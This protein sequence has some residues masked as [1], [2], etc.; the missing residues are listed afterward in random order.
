MA[1]A[2]LQSVRDALVTAYFENY[3]SDDEFVF[4]YDANRSKPVYPYWKFDNFDL[5]NWDEDECFAELRFFKSE[6]PAL[7]DC[8]GIPEKIVCSQR[9]ICG[10]MEGLCILLKRLSYPC[11]YCY[12]I[13]GSLMNLLTQHLHC[14]TIQYNTRILALTFY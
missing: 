10:G 11:R 8:F 13:H 14:S 5:N 12:I 9:S 2:G 6:L 4:L 7:M 1:G 3:I